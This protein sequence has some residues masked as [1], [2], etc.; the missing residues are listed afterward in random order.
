[1]LDTSTELEMSECADAQGFAWSDDADLHLVARLEDGITRTAMLKSPVDPPIP[2][3]TTVTELE[4]VP[5]AF[6]GA[7]ELP[8]AES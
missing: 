4:A 1:M 6:V 2:D 7:K 8:A 5:G 3:P